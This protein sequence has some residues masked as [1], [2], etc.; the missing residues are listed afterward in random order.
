MLKDLVGK[1]LSG[2]HIVPMMEIYSVDEDGRKTA[3]VLILFNDKGDIGFLVG[4]NQQEPVK[5][6][7][8]E[9]EAA[10]LRQVAIAKLSPAERKL[11]KL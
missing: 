4:E 11:L 10:R 8:D 1:D 2:W 6:F 5:L 9:E 3:L 7:K